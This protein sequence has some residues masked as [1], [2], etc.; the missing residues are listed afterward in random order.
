MSAIIHG[1]FMVNSWS[2]HGQLMVNARKVD[3]RLPVK[4]NSNSHGA[5]PVRKIISMLHWIRT[6][7]LSIKN[8]PPM[9]VNG[10]GGRGWHRTREGRPDHPPPELDQTAF[11]NRLDLYH[12]SPDLGERQFK[13]KT[14]TGQFD[15]TLGADGDQGVS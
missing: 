3:V 7:R 12:R 6:G 5:R 2:I 9:K 14:R 11:F 8:S 1:Q 10:V 15:P 13:S 4:G